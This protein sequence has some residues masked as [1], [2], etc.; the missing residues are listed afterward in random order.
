MFYYLKEQLR[1]L[2]HENW[3]IKS[4]LNK[5]NLIIIMIINLDLLFKAIKSIGGLQGKVD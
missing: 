4:Y 1:L 2:L 3:F 5:K